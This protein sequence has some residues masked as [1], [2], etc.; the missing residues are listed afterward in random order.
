MLSSSRKLAQSK[1]T[2]VADEGSYSIA[3]NP[4]LGT[5]LACNVPV[6]FADTTP[7]FYVRNNDGKAN[8]FGKGLYLHCIK[9]KLI[10]ATAGQHHGRPVC[11]SGTDPATR[12]S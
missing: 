2:N 8:P 4:T 5:V 1:R 7:L 6:A 11:S 12:V 10:C 9:I 3:T